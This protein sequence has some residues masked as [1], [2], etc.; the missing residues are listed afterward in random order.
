[1][2]ELGV[3]HL[4]WRRNISTSYDSVAGDL[5]F[6]EFVTRYG[7]SMNAI[8]SYDLA[9]MPQFRPAD[10]AWLDDR[11][12]VVACGG[13]Y[14]SGLYKLSDLRVPL[15]TNV[16]PPPVERLTSD[17]QVAEF[18]QQSKFSVF[19]STCHP[20]AT[21]PGKLGFAQIGAREAVELY[22]RGKRP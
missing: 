7:V 16:R 9:A 3:T 8:G 15:G 10:R 11:V 18:L 5:V 2:R 21:H 1:M 20:A 6:F 17:E 19:E 13:V 12:T 22:M 14:D 4:L